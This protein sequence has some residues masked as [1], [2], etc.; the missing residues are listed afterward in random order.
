MA[1]I[2]NAP[3]NELD[4]PSNARCPYQAS[5]SR[6]AVMAN[7][8]LQTALISSLRC[9]TAQPTAAGGNKIETTL[10]ETITNHDEA[11]FAKLSAAIQRESKCSNQK[12]G[13]KK[14]HDKEVGKHDCKDTRVSKCIKRLR[15]QLN[16]S[17]LTCSN[18]PI[19]ATLRQCTIGWFGYFLSL[20]LE[21]KLGAQSAWAVFSP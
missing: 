15:L 11:L 2:E 21:K 4:V 16:L 5:G 3:L 19:K 18:I 1:E 20:L 14:L 13:N 10:V 17:T 9:P 8:W 12:V 7:Q 6:V